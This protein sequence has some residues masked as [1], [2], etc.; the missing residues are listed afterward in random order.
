MKNIKNWEQQQQKQKQ[1]QTKR[2]SSHYER[3]VIIFIIQKNR[4]NALE[5]N[6]LIDKVIPLMLS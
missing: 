6:S 5:I 2:A 4:I 1:T 3:I